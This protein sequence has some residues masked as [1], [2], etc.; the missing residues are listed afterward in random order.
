MCLRFAVLSSHFE[1]NRRTQV[2]LSGCKAWTPS[3]LRKKRK[4]RQ[5]LTMESKYHPG[6]RIGSNFSDPYASSTRG[7]KR[8]RIGV[9]VSL[10]MKKHPKIATIERHSRVHFRD[11]HKKSSVHQR[12]SVDADP[13][14]RV[15]CIFIALVLLPCLWDDSPWSCIVRLILFFGLDWSWLHKWFG[16]AQCC[17]HWRSDQGRFWLRTH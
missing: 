4:S 2:L 14:W 16:K 6:V 10:Q 11:L 8:L 13:F 17:W 3:M 9:T 15:L 7:T 12:L 5:E 1:N